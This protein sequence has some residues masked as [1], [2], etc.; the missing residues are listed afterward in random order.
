M[1]IAALCAILLALGVGVHGWV[2]GLAQ[3]PEPKDP[4]PSTPALIA[5]GRELYLEAACY[6][7]HGLNA[8]GNFGPDLTHLGKTDAE[9]FDFV[10]SSY[11]GKVTNREGW[12]IINYLRSLSEHAPPTYTQ[13]DCIFCHEQQQITPNIVKEWR[14]AR[15][16]EPTNTQCVD[17]HGNDHR[18]IIVSKGRVPAAICAECH[19]K[20]YEESTSGGGHATAG[21]AAW[22]QRFVKNSPRELMDMSY[23][24]GHEVAHR[25]TSCH[26]RHTFA[27]DEARDPR[28]CGVCHSGPEHPELDA[29]AN[30]KHGLIWKREGETAGLPPV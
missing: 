8:K 6:A 3:T 11:R 23:A 19:A 7:C 10:M 25:C 13:A 12:K 21:S 18:V 17:C 1:R 15:D 5:E 9:I 29:Y 20:R 24:V 27:Q 4:Y 14:N 16:G 30:S 26:S 28:T 2:A 22:A